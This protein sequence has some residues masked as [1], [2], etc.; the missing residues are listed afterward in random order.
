[1][2]AVSSS[3][4]E[5]IGRSGGESFGDAVSVLRILLQCSNSECCNYDAIALECKD[6]SVALSIRAGC[7]RMRM[8]MRM[9]MRMYW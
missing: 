2:V 8:C 5:S 1:M 6:D 7:S 9:R 3:V 4:C